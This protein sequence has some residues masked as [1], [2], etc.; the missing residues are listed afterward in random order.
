MSRPTPACAGITG[1]PPV[2]SEA[3]SAYPRV[4]GD[5]RGARSGGADADGL[6]PRARGSRVDLDSVERAG[7]PTPACAGIT[8]YRTASDRAHM[9]YPRVRG[10][11]RLASEGGVEARG[12]PPRARGSL[13]SF[14]ADRAISGPTPACAGITWL[15]TCLVTVS[16]AYPRVRG[17]HPA[18]DDEQGAL[19]GLPPRARGSRPRPLRGVLRLRPTPACA[20]ITAMVCPAR[21]SLQAYPR[22]RGD[23]R[24]PAS[25]SAGA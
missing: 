16:G 12:L 21:H 11:H 1:R 5:H 2:Q 6:P 3:L 15:T 14:R 23:H 7:G 8:W 10:D 9:A 13:R 20:G 18:G 4:R 25:G 24:W 17:D 19:Q 22:V